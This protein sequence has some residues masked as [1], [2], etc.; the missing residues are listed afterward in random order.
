MAR[1]V[2]FK[3]ANIWKIIKIKGKIRSTH[4]YKFVLQKYIFSNTLTYSHNS[5][6][7]LNFVVPYKTIY[8]QI[9]WG[10]FHN[11]IST[12]EVYLLINNHFIKID[13]CE[14]MQVCFSTTFAVFP[15]SPS[16]F[17][18]VDK[19]EKHQVI[20]FTYLHSLFFF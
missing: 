20:S 3:S 4:V 6:S 8:S 17:F 16:S 15:P 2:N 13:T 5:I 19:R 11:L 18:E 10:Y 9:H 1:K 7:Q 12:L 14:S